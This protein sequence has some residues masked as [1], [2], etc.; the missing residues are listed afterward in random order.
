MVRPGHIKGVNN[1]MTQLYYMWV[2]PL[3]LCHLEANS[4]KNYLLCLGSKRFQSGWARLRNW[5]D[6][7]NN[8]EASWESYIALGPILWSTAR[9]RKNDLSPGSSSVPNTTTQLC[10][11]KGCQFSSPDLLGHPSNRK[12]H[13][14]CWNGC[15]KKNPIC[16]QCQKSLSLSKATENHFSPGRC[17]HIID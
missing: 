12:D 9:H 14:A 17:D 15:W 6:R 5:K 11:S 3:H 8:S 2:D 7:H 16:P 13:G 1:V 4:V 10:H